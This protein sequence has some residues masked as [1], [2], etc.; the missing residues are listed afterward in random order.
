MA[1][2]TRIRRS[3]GAKNHITGEFTRFQIVVEYDDVTGNVTDIYS[4][5]D[6]DVL[7]RRNMK[8]VDLSLD[9]TGRKLS[10]D[11]T[12]GHRSFNSSGLKMRLKESK[13]VH[14]Q[15]RVVDSYD[16]WHLTVSSQKEIT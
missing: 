12:T 11:S 10:I 9:G 3:M 7:R 1:I 6:I 16:G 13:T 5:G 14:G 4:R 2:I 8:S 15:I